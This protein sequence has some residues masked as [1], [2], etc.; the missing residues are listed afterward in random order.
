M[1]LYIKHSNNSKSKDEMCAGIIKD[2]LESPELNSD[3]ILISKNIED[4]P[5][6][7]PRD[8]SNYYLVCIND[9]L[10][11][12]SRMKYLNDPEKWL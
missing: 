6:E 12:Y 5:N 4:L 8:P 1:E 2:L 10:I 7:E 3:F 9:K 11:S